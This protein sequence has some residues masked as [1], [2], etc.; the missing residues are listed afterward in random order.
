MATPQERAAEHQIAISSLVIDIVA[1]VSSI[2]ALQDQDWSFVEALGHTRH[3]LKDV[4][5]F[6]EGLEEKKEDD[7]HDNR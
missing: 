2:A 6:L 1:R 3:Q 7:S 5:A 4:L